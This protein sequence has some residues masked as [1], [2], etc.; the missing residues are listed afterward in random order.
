MTVEL[1]I[2]ERSGHLDEEFNELNIIF[3]FQISH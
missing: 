2:E 1:H 3:H